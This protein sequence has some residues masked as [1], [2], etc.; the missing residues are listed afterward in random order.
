M[1][2]LG[3][4]SV[5][6][7]LK[8]A[9]DVIYVALW[10][11]IGLLSAISLVV[12]LMSFNPELLT[13]RLRVN[14]NVDELTSNGP[15]LAAAMDGVVSPAAAAEVGRLGGLA[16]LNLEGIWS[17][18]EDA[19]QQLERIASAS[20]ETATVTMQEIYREPVKPELM[21][22]RRTMWPTLFSSLAA[23]TTAMLAGSKSSLILSARNCIVP[24]I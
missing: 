22:L 8:V 21:M 4:G 12:L 24:W 18:Y 6:S 5:S 3:P 15:L 9:L 20:A 19:E 16:V 1:R 14:G 2:A 13:N 7:F 11:W 17:R 10:V 23:P